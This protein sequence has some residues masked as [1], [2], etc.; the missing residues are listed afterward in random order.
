VLKE[1]LNQIMRLVSGICN[2]TTNANGVKGTS[3]GGIGVLGQSDNNIGI[4]GRAPTAGRFEGNVEVTGDISLLN[5]DCAE[6][7]DVADSE[8]KNVEAGTVMILTENGSL[9]SSY[10]EYD[11]K[12]AVL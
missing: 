4:L 3:T 12:V 5:A 11:K 9:Q 1:K 6:D 8:L 2:F 7:F 10:K